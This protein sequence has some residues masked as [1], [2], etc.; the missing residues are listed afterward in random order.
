MA[1]GGDNYTVL[2]GKERTFGHADLEAFVSYIK[3]TFKGGKITAEKEGRIT[4]LH[5]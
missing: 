2:K 3:D 1:S 4:N 5:N